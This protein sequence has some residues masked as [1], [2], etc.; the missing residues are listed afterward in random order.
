MGSCEDRN[1]PKLCIIYRNR[2]NLCHIPH[3]RATHL[4]LGICTNNNTAVRALAS[5]LSK[6]KMLRHLDISHNSIDKQGC[7]ILRNVLCAQDQQQNW[8]LQ[9]LHMAGNQSGLDGVAYRPGARVCVCVCV[10]V[11]EGGS[12]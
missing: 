11:W 8:N 4:S 10:C 5:Y 2:K 12:E 9:C 7:E 3:K 1:Q 6:D